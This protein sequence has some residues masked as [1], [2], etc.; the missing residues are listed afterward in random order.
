M[1]WLVL[2]PQDDR[3]RGELLVF[4]PLG[5]LDEEWPLDVV[6]KW[7]MEEEVCDTLYLVITQVSDHGQV[8][9]LVQCN[10]L[11]SCLGNRSY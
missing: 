4:N 10:Q 6:K 2:L 5:Q 11:A 8:R 7:Q 1:L 9:L 3:I